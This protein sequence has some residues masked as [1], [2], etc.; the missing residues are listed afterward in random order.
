VLSP[1][2]TPNGND[3]AAAINPKISLYSIRLRVSKTQ[4][5]QQTAT[6]IDNRPPRVIRWIFTFYIAERRAHAPLVAG[7]EVTHGVGVVVTENHL[8]RTATSGCVARLVGQ[9]YYYGRLWKKTC[10]WFWTSC[11][12]G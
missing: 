2:N 9:M 6:A 10:S 4:I 1:P 8:N 11:S 12:T 5:D 7:A 3:N